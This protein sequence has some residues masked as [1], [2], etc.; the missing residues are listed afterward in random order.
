[1]VQS[2][3]GK[4]LL[5]KDD[6]RIGYDDWDIVDG[7]IVAF[8]EAWFD[9]DK[10]FGTSTCDKDD[11]IDLYAKYDPKNESLTLSY[12]IRYA[13]GEEGSEII[14]EDFDDREK[15]AV[16]NLMEQTGLNNVIKTML[17]DK[18]EDCF[19]ESFRKNQE[20][21]TRFNP[22]DD[23]RDSSDFNFYLTGLTE[24]IDLKKRLIDASTDE[25]A[26][27]KAVRNLLKLDDPLQVVYKKCMELH[28]EEIERL[29]RFE[30]DSGQCHEAFEQ[31]AEDD[32]EQ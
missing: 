10:R 21:I 32:H 14:V 18:M 6:L 5:E 13:N 19:F 17:R 27:I 8:L 12:I 22:E 24:I 29:G 7:E 20:R 1:M 4:W 16:L 31:A 25:E 9:V 11:Y 23:L 28:E 15:E 2:D 3:S 30:A 26:P